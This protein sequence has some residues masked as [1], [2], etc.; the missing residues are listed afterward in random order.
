[1]DV[2][3]RL[4]LGK[5][6][7]KRLF[8]RVNAFTY[9]MYYLFFPLS[10]TGRL[11]LPVDRRGL[12]SFYR[13]DHGARDGS[14]LA[15]WIRPVLAEHGFADIGEIV[16]MTLPRVLGYVFNP[17][18]FWLCFDREGS[19][20]TVLCEVNNTFGETHS[21]LCLRPDRGVLTGEDMLHGEK[22]FHVSPFL[23]REGH[24][25]FRF[26]IQDDAVGI[27]IDHYAADGRLQLVTALTGRLVPMT[28]QSLRAA[29]WR[30]PLIT[31]KA[32]LLIHWQAVKLLTKGIKYVPR[33][34]QHGTRQS[35]AENMKNL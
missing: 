14:E 35:T 10:A 12:L 13:K 15:G 26:N 30:Y 21:Y 11:P 3:P 31:V 1:M 2:T 34:L 4:F 20:R 27:W 33:P 32:I 28:K 25:R 18:S 16:L 19:L 17:V 5:V 22:L 23:P 9:G 24:Y 29:F 7:H 8:P 6:M